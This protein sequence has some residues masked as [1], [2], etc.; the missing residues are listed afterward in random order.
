MISSTKAIAFLALAVLAICAGW[1]GTRIAYSSGELAVKAFTHINTDTGIIHNFGV[2]PTKI[3]HRTYRTHF[4]PVNTIINIQ[5]VNFIDATHSKHTA[6][7]AGEDQVIA[8]VFAAPRSG[9]NVKD[10][11]K[12]STIGC[13]EVYIVESLDDGATWSKP[14]VISRENAND[15]VHRGSPSA[16]YDREENVIYIAYTY[17]NVANGDTAIGLVKK[18]IGEAYRK[19]QLIK[20]PGDQKASHPKLTVTNPAKHKGEL[21]LAFIGNLAGGDKTVLYTKS[22]NGGAA[23]SAPLDL[24]PNDH[25]SNHYVTIS[26]VGIAGNHDV[27]M[28]YSENAGTEIK[29]VYSHNSGTSW[30]TPKKVNNKPGLVPFMKACGQTKALGVF[31]SMFSEKGS[32][33]YE[34]VYYNTTDSTYKQMA[35]PFKEL[36]ELTHIPMAECTGLADPGVSFVAISG[37]KNLFVFDDY[38]YDYP[39]NH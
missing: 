9:M 2:T 13:S 19:E 37:S 32:Y 33:N 31:F 35:L 8:L 16:T 26:S 38:D 6:A 36:P 4:G 11:T 7:T 12:D 23:W 5:G 22:V 14:I 18:P 1:K 3:I 34:M 20:I 28:A 15:V 29:F 39:E 17:T 27:F 30:S 25:K 21:H 24:T 10:C